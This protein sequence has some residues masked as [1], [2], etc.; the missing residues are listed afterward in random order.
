MVKQKILGGLFCTNHAKLRVKQ[1]I[2]GQSAD[3]KQAER[4]LRTM[5]RLGVSR[6]KNKG[7]VPQS[8]DKCIFL[9]SIWPTAKKF[10]KKYVLVVKKTYTNIDIPTILTVLTLE[11]FNSRITLL[12]T[13]I[14][15][16][17]SDEKLARSLDP[18]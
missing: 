18:N 7:E 14:P 4:T 6:L 1:R 9:P 10:G 2:L 13:S 3:N 16:D 12:D 17:V 11:Q 8:D 15:A 5:Y